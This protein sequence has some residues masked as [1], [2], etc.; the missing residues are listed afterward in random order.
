MVKQFLKS[1]VK[2]VR[3]LV[4]MKIIGFVHGKSSVNWQTYLTL[5][6]LLGVDT[7]IIDVLKRAA[8][9][10]DEV[11][12]IKEFGKAENVGEV[13]EVEKE[14]KKRNDDEDKDESEEK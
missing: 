4:L 14:E 10:T 12:N 2:K 9:K 11:E 1:P 3:V 5:S 8:E 13:S 7:F 6:I